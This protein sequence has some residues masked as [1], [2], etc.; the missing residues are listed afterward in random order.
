MTRINTYLALVTVEL[1]GINSPIEKYQLAN[2]M[3]QT[4]LLCRLPAR[5]TFLQRHA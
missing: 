5:D 4:R 3:K 2:W 1:N